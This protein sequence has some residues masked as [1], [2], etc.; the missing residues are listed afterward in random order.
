[1]TDC[2]QKYVQ[3]C[4]RVLQHYTDPVRCSTG[5]ESFAPF[6]QDW[7]HNPSQGSQYER[8]GCHLDQSFYMPAAGAPFDEQHSRNDAEAGREAVAAAIAALDVEPVNGKR[9]R[10]RKAKVKG[11]EF[12]A[13]P[14]T[15]SRGRLLHVCQLTEC[16]LPAEDWYMHSKVR[17]T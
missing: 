12:E 10:R 5:F 16:K 14:L 4:Q 8:T 1:M 6:A 7:Q 13:A 15:G 9:P 3:N 2:T 11:S 17:K